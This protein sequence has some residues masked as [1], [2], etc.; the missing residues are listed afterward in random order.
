MPRNRKPVIEF[1]QGADDL[2]YWKLT[3]G[4]GRTLDSSGEGFSS[5]ANAKRNFIKTREA[6][7]ELLDEDIAAAIKASK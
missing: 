1:Y 4:N 6:M 3:H 7:N 2:W 5:R